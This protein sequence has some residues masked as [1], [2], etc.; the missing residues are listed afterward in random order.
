M[1]M[2]YWRKIF[3]SHLRQSGIEAE[4]VDP[5]QGRVPRTA[6]TRYYFT[7]SLE[8]REKVIQAL[9]KLKKEI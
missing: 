9:T 6:F 3:A 4:I 2:A 7:P 8:Y 5:L 1:N